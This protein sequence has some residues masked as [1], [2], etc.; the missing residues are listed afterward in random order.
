MTPELTR[1]REIASAARPG[2]WAQ[3]EPWDNLHEAQVIRCGGY[4][5]AQTG[6]STWGA[7]DAAH[8]AAFS[9]ATALRLLD[10]LERMEGV[11]SAARNAECGTRC[12]LTNWPYEGGCSCNARRIADA[13]AKLDEGAR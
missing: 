9:P 1:L 11:L 5:V 12:N 2:E 8:I 13:L 7:P 6:T 3:M 4:Y 10:R